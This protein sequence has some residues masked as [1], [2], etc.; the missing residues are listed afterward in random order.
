MTVTGDVRS[1]A[2]AIGEGTDRSTRSILS[3]KIG[4]VIGREVYGGFVEVASEAAP[5]PRR[6]AELPDLSNGP[7]FFDG[8]QWWFF[9][10][11]AVFGFCYLA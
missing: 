1:Y 7:H 4:L 10:P 2:M 9:G 8:L 11:L 5:R 6:P 3:A